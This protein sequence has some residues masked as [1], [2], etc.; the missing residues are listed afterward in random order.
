MPRRN[1]P[2][3]ITR[4]SNERVTPSVTFRGS[5]P[6]AQVR[7]GSVKYAQVFAV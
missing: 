5:A 1:R 2:Y 6:V 7:S 4:T 3:F